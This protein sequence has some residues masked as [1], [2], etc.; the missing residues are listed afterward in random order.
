MF[1]FMTNETRNDY[2]GQ[3]AERIRI[4]QELLVKAMSDAMRHGGAVA[5]LFGCLAGEGNRKHGQDMFDATPDSGNVRSD[6]GMD[7]SNDG[8]GVRKAP[9]RFDDYGI[10]EGTKLTYTKDNSVKAVVAG[11]RQVRYKGK[12]WTLTGLATKL[13]GSPA[14]GL[15]SF[16]YDGE[17]LVNL[18]NRIDSE[19]AAA[20][21]PIE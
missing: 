11:N 2:G 15:A 17:R 5:A 13:N 9:F 6:G 19:R 12:L 18:R 1:F 7:R 21:V 8:D 4:E 10:P 14:N 3:I 16:R 20:G